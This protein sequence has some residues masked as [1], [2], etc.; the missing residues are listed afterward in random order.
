MYAAYF[1]GA[2]EPNPGG[3]ATYGAVI[4][5]DRDRVWACSE[6][7]CPEPGRERQTS[8]NVAEYSGFLAVL[9]WFIDQRL[10]DAEIM[11]FGDSKLVIK[12]MFDSRRIKK[13]LYVPLA[14]AGRQMLTQFSNINGQWI[15]RDQNYL[16]DELAKAAQRRG[17]PQA[18]GRLDFETLSG[19]LSDQW[20]K[21]YLVRAGNP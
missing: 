21:G 14:L 13:G 18:R 16:A 17:G 2:C 9:R 5:H 8:N 10:T 4:L 1:Y 20:I 6:V 19:R 11:V 3:T 7:F 15:P 12:Q